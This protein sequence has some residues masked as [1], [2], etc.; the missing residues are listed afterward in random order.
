MQQEAQKCML[1]QK[2]RN[3]FKVYELC[4]M[5]LKYYKIRFSSKLACQEEI[6]IH[7]STIVLYLVGFPPT[8]LHVHLT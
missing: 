2:M 1:E 5:K 3:W 8:F 7:L 6:L 4:H